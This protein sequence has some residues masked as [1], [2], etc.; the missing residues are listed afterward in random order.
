MGFRTEAKSASRVLLSMREKLLNMVVVML[1]I[2][3]DLVAGILAKFHCISSSLPMVFGWISG[4]LSGC[5]VW[6]G[7]G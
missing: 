7:C 3:L 1:T 6:E 4:S 5:W 2:N